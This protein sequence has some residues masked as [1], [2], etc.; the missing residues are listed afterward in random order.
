LYVSFERYFAFT[1]YRA[2]SN[3][4][5]G[6]KIIHADVFRYPPFKSIFCAVIGNG[7]Q[8]LATL[9]L[10]ILM[11]LLGLFN[12]HRHGAMNAAGFVVYALTCCIAGFVSTRLYRQLEG[13]V[14]VHHVAL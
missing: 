3:E 4:D 11:A 12:V 2:E 6:W 5:H 7:T 8:V 10:I 1:N 14:S 9:M 13:N